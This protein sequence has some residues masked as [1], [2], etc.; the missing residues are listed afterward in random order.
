MLSAR[1]IFLSASLFL[2][3]LAL[4]FLMLAL[5]ASVTRTKPLSLEEQFSILNSSQLGYEAIDLTCQLGIPLPVG[6][7]NIAVLGGSSA[8]GAFATPKKS[9]SYVLHERLA[10]STQGRWSVHN[11]AR[12][13]KASYWMKECMRHLGPGK[14]DLWLTYAGHN[15]FINMFL[16]GVKR[17]R[18]FLENPFAL[19]LLR[20]LLAFP[21]AGLLRPQLKDEVPTISL[22]KFLRDSAIILETSEKNY[23]EMIHMAGNAGRRLVLSTV[24]SNLDSAPDPQLMTGLNSDLKAERLFHLAKAA[25]A[26]KR[27]AEGLSLARFA[28]DYDPTQWRAPSS[29]NE[30]LRGLAAEFPRSVLLFDVEKEFEAE[31]GSRMIGCEFFGSDRYCDHVHPNDF[32]HAWIA[33]RLERLLKQEGYLSH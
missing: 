31:F 5:Y 17:A 29:F 23:R 30:M 26:G 21:A 32:T 33:E 28:R 11:L 25:Y 20:K 22:D 14:V 15:E 16:P 18:F 10:K 6:P 13:G 12:S 8:Q 7:N 9:F 2:A 1:K 19:G 24:I 27:P 3:G 4:P